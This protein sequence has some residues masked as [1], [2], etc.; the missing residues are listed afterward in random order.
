MINS[1]SLPILDTLQKMTNYLLVN[2]DIPIATKR[3]QLGLVS[4]H[5][6]LT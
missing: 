6:R 4:T 2:V 5:L 3:P 1:I